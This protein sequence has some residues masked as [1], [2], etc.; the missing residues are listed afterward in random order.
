VSQA[1]I[2][3]S[4]LEYGQWRRECVCGAESW[5]EPVVNRVRLDPYDP[6]TSQHAGQCEFKNAT[7]ANILK[8]LLKV[9]PGL[10]A[11]YVW[12]TCGSCEYEWAVADYA[13][14]K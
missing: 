9:K 13:S 7:D 4:R 14:V 1:W 2:P 10:D 3:W 8:V 11:G 12:V 5:T 6:A